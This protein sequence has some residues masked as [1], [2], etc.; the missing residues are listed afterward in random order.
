[1]DIDS[2]IVPIGVPVTA[3]TVLF[4]VLCV[5]SMAYSFGVKYP[6]VKRYDLDQTWE[7][8]P[9]L[10]SATEI[11]P[12]VLPRHAEAGDVDGG[13]ASGKW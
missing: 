2:L 4:V 5:V 8:A 1:M 12:M 11:E 13:S 7:H 9:L 6:K 10:F 3:L